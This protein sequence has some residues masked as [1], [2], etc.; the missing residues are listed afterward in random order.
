[1][2]VN[3]LQCDKSP[4]DPPVDGPHQAHRQPPFGATFPPDI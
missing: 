1:M 3:P 4:I 2:I